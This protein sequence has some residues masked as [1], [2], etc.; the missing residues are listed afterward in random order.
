MDI[1]RASSIL[2]KIGYPKRGS[3]EEITDIYSFAK[4]I[5]ATWTCEQLEELERGGK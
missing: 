3:S 2:R 5:Q 1:K 4:E